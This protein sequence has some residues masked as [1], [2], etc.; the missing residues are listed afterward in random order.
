M[1]VWIDGD[2]CPKLIK[3]ILFRAA[4]KRHVPLL[5]VANHV[6]QIPPSPWIKRVVVAHGFDAADR[7]IVDHIE[8]NDLVITSDILLAELIIDRE[9]L[10]LNSKGVL[11]SKSNIKQAVAMR[12]LNESL[13]N[14]GLINNGPNPLS[15]KDIQL[16]SNHLDKILTQFAQ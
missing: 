15:T 1:K 5:I 16:F 9:A 12:N 10:A 4:M 3:Q 7:Y 11:Y 13:R 8:K 2:A 14:N 6:A